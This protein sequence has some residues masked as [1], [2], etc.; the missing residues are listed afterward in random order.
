MGIQIG[1]K[2]DSGFDDPLGMLQDCHRRIERFLHILCVVAEQAGGRGM[3]EEES[4]A[5]AAALH[6]FREGGRRH[7][8]DE[9]ES[10]FPRL[11]AAEA[12]ER[13]D[14]LAHLVEDHRR[15]GL[16]HKQIEALYGTWAKMGALSRDAQQELRS[17]TRELDGIYSAHIRLEESIVFPHAARVLDKADIA[18]M[19]LEFKQ[20]RS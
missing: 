20:R 6:Y 16:L 15:A 18:A 4:V 5:V 1:A 13:A 11:R 14:D 8:A 17:A 12:S 10:L 3:T 2:P 7:N 19:G 9:E